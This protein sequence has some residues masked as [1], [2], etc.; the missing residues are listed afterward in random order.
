M[1]WFTRLFHKQRAEKQL[2]A[3]LR[4][5]ME[6]QVAD[7]VASGMTP[8]EA[9]RR[10]NLAFGS[11]E[12]VKEDCRESRRVNVIETLLQDTQFALR[13]L[14]KNLGFTAVAVLTLALGIGA[15]TAI[16]SIVNS[17][18]LRP[19][20]YKDSSRIVKV[21]LNTAMFPTFSLGLTWPAFQQIRSRAASLEQ[22]AVYSD[23]EKT[24][25]GKGEPAILDLANVSGG[26][27][28]E[29]GV[30]VELGRL[31]TDQDQQSGQTNVVVISDA[32][33]RTR[34]GADSS[35]IGRTLILDKEPYTV[36]GVAAKGFS[37]P[38]GC[39]AWLP[40]SLTSADELNQTFFMLQFI[41]KLC[42]GENV[43]Q[44]KPQLF[45]IAERIVKGNPEL[46]AGYSFSAQP[47]LE[48]RVQNIRSAYLVLL[49]AATLVLL[50]ACANLASLLLARGS[51]RRREMALRAALGASRGRLFRQGLVES[52]LL[53][54][55]GGGL[56]V[57]LAAGGVQ[58]FRA[59]APA[60]TT[61]LAEISVDSTLLWFSLISA[62]AAGILFGLAPAR[63]ASRMDPNESLK[64]GSGASSGAARSTRQSTLGSALVVVEVALAFILLIGSALMTQRVSRLLHQ[65]PGFRT[66][67]LLTLGLPQPPLSQNEAESEKQFHEGTVRL[68]QII[69][70]LQQVQTVA[71]VTA[72]AQGMLS[73]T[74]MMHSHLQVEEAIPLK[75]GEE[76]HA[77]TRSVYPSYFRTLGMPLL[78]GREFTDHDAGKAPEVIIVNETM[79]RAY[80]GTL[81]VLGKRI[82][83]SWD[84][85]KR[86]IWNEIIG[87]V[88]DAREVRIGKESSPEYY[89]SLLQSGIG[90]YQ[91]FVRTTG[92]AQALAGPITRA[93]WALYPEQP[94][95]RV[96]T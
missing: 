73:G 61:R 77:I 5:H 56:G 84:K 75:P 28:E 71:S 72:G 47:L 65:N 87:V 85:D 13:M 6:R 34:F 23:A 17:V 4:F 91:L 38:E 51:G 53:A 78:R 54:L 32:L 64:E 57:A 46:S 50:I 39:E 93:L 67:H 80:W 76:R 20:P 8:D 35:I 3:E 37:F 92:D 33:W 18:I 15:N 49:G 25:T 83:V 70:R 7:Y 63:R 81:D 14:R 95:T 82:S 69:E 58:L 48:G 59:V 60:D 44:L 79:A 41:G 16:F 19:L 21:T 96:M 12:G 55:L 2:D 74:S 62:L 40:L 9:R 11:L 86:P 89:L 42:R 30:S 22:T 45:T 68:Q 26:F 1:R 94:V 27:F 90:D 31:F 10:A 66:D 36:V 88:A 29:L 24:L 52:C 43:E